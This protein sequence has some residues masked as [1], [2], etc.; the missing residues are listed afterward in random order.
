MIPD[1][2]FSKNR[3][4]SYFRVLRGTAVL[5]LS[6]TLVWAQT[7]SSPGWTSLTDGTGMQGWHP[8]NPKMGNEW[9][10]AAGVKLNP[11]DEH[12]FLIEAGQGIAVNGLKGKTTDLLTDV[13]FGD[14]EAHLEFVVPKGSNSGVYFMGHYEI[15]ILDSYGN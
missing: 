15:Q 7:G 10:T 12:F 2:Q 8:R 5:L 9:L 3:K 13:Q 14:I 11:Q 6:Y 1:N 4:K